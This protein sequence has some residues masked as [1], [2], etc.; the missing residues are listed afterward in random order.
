[1]S[2]K[3]TKIADFDFLK[4]SNLMLCKVWASE[5]KDLGIFHTFKCGIFP[6]NQIQDL[7]NDQNC[8]F[9]YPKIAKL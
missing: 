2:S 5:C 6:R 4:F 8:Y 3:I 7:Q 1:M 9:D